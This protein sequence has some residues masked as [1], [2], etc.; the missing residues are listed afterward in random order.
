M[1]RVKEFKSEISELKA[2]L[3]PLQRT[4]KTL[5]EGE[6]RRANVELVELRQR[7]EYFKEQH[8]ADMRKRAYDVRTARQLLE[9]NQ[10]LLAKV[11]ELSASNAS[12]IGK[13]GAAVRKSMLE[14]RQSSAREKQL[15][16]SVALAARSVEAAKHAEAEARRS[17]A[18][19]EQRAEVAE[20]LQRTADERA[21]EA[22]QEA[23][24]AAAAAADAEEATSDAEYVKAVL[25]GKLRRSEQRALE[26]AQKAAKLRAEAQRGPRDRS[27]DE[28]AQLGREA[29][30]KAAQRE[31]LYLTDFLQSHEWRMQD[32]AA[33]LDELGLV[34]KLFDTAPFYLEYVNRTKALMIQLEKSEFGEVFGMY[35]HYEMNLTF[36]KI[37]R[38]NQ[39]ACMKFAKELNHYNSKVLL[40][41]PHLKDNPHH[42]TIVKVPRLAP[43]FH[44]LVATKK[45]IEEKLNVKPGENGRLAYT[46]FND[47]VQQLM[48]QDCGTQGMPALSHFDGRDNKVHLVISFDGTGFGSQ[49]VNTIALNNP[50]TSQSAQMLRI[51][52]IGNCADDRSGTTRLL[53]PNLSL[54]NDMM[55]HPEKLVKVMDAM[56]SFIL[57]VVLDVAALRHTEHVSNSG[58]CCCGRDFALRQTPVKPT[59]VK[60]MYELLKECHEPTFEE[61]CI[62]SHTPLPGEDLPRACPRCSFGHDRDAVAGEYAALLADEVKLA[63]DHTKKGKAAF[64]RWRMEHAHRHRNIQPGRYG[65]P[66]FR[67][68]FNR[69]LLDALHLAELN[70]P[71]I[72]WKHCIL[73]NASDDARALISEQLK[74]WRHPLDCRRKDDNRQR[75]QKWF[76]GEKWA[77]FCLGIK[78]SPGGPRGIAAIMLIIAQDMQ[79]NGNTA[80]PAAAAAAPPPP[81]PAAAPPAPAA[82]RR[83]GAFQARAIGAVATDT[84]APSPAPAI[85]MASRVEVE[86]KPTVMEKAADPADLEVIRELYG[87]RAQT[88]INSLLAFD[89]FFAWY[90]PLKDSINM[91]SSLEEREARAL[92]NMRCAIDVHEVYERCSI[93]NHKSFM[94]HGA[95][96]KMTRDI[97]TVGDIWAYCL[98]ALELQNAETKRIASS[99]GSRRLTMS[100]SGQ[101]RRG[102]GPVISPTAGYSSSMALSTLRKLLGAQ[103]LRRG[104]GIISLPESRRKERLLAGRTKLVSKL[105]KMEVLL[106][107]YKAREDTCIKAFVRLLAA[108]DLPAC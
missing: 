81:P 37:H 75:A 56:V 100:T 98:S 103:M 52:G 41:N 54:I 74:E 69:V 35:L 105:V 4:F 30:Y 61:R 87:S 34:K 26:H 17:E 66:M 45:K 36:D 90:Y 78:G 50:W 47:V 1:Q 107:D 77:S 22:I 7:I 63:S 8:A 44:Q 49:Q 27:V 72:A 79:L 40:Y 5:V 68:N 53:G 21:D 93:R 43:P 42:R 86:H 91:D 28:W 58:W 65:A 38:L 19:A 2:E 57:F 32:V 88:I 104:D 97:L 16:S 51:F 62:L 99:G 10:L 46:C 83:R 15:L 76:T 67:H 39:A 23:E 92:D 94:P 33:A 20:E 6:A 12:L 13:H 25:E 59:N 102:A 64:S 82:A 70:M 60:E 24:A 31:R 101:T 95:I 29:E 80:A 3:Q 108:Q 55:T 106:S 14:K 84:A 48:M 71:K 73:T 11:G 89:A 85:A 96:F 9:E 18:D